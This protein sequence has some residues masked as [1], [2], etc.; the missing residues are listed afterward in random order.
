MAAGI[1][2]AVEKGEMPKSKLKGASKQMYQSMKGTGELHKFAATKRKG[3]PEKKPSEAAEYVA[4]LF[5]R[6]LLEKGHAAGCTCGFCKNKGSF[7]KKKTEPDTPTEP[8]S[9]E[10]RKL[11]YA[12]REKLSSGSFVFPKER[13]Y[14]IPD[15]AHARNALARVAQHGSS[16]E[17]AKVRAAVH[18]K[19]PDIGEQNESKA[20]GEVKLSKGVNLGGPAARAYHDMTSSQAMTAGWKPKAYIRAAGEISGMNKSGQMQGFKNKLAGETTAGKKL[21]KTRAGESMPSE[22]AFQIV[23]ALIG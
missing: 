8:E 14:P 18:S 19:Y 17:K 13:R 20:P 22:V 15:K 23:E 12:A 1:A 3:L 4:N 2:H 10:E 7:G 6:T 21:P 11:S 5:G 9:V 16:E